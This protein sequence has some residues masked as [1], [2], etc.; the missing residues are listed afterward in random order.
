MERNGGGKGRKVR[1]RK[2]GRG[3]DPVCIFKFSSQ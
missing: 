1:V 2:G 3:E